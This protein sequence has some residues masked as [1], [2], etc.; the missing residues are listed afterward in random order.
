MW[1][2]TAKNL[3]IDDRFQFERV[4]YFVVNE[5][6]DL[7]NNKIEFNRTVELKESKDKTSTDWSFK[8]NAIQFLKNSWINKNITT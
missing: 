8:I 2:H 4:A 7:K 1:S 6:L 3:K 5:K